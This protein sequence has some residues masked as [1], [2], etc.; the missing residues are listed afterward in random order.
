MN[1]NIQIGSKVLVT[2]NN[3][4]Y[5]PEGTQCRAVFGTVKAILTDEAT[6]GVKTNRGATNW[7]VEIG[8]MTIA[9]CQI[10]YVIKT[11][12]CVLDK[13]FVDEV[14]VEKD[15]I[16]LFDAPSRVYNADKC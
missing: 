1:P 15:K 11:D 10:Y 14:S 2:T 4:F 9:G 12:S 8:N 7:Y 13:G 5:T 3:W 16:N 6:L